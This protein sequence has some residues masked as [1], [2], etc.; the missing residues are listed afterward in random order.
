MSTK[1]KTK[2]NFKKVKKRVIGTLV[3]IGIIS[4]VGCLVYG[5]WAARNILKPISTYASNFVSVHSVNSENQTLIFVLI[6]DK[7][8]YVKEARLVMIN[9]QDLQVK[10]IVIPQDTLVH[11]PYGLNEFKLKS[12]YKITQLEKPESTFNLVNQ[13]L[14]EYFGISTQKMIIVKNDLPEGKTFD[15]WIQ[16]PFTMFKIA[17]DENWVKQNLETNE[18]R[19]NILQIAHQIQIIP[20]Q[21]K[22]ELKVEQQGIVELQKSVDNSS[23]YITD[24]NKLD[25]YIKKTY[26]T[27]AILNEKA[28]IAIQNGTESQG[29]AS[30]VSRIISNSGGVVIELKNADKNQDTTNIQIHDKK[31]LNSQTLQ[32][33]Q[34]TI[35]GAKVEINSEINTKSDITIILGRDYAQIIT[36]NNIPQTSR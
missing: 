6:L 11:L 4:S 3:F 21:N 12:L 2:N 8:N 16:D 25:T 28:D 33:I 24:Q 30:K 14:I 18:S 29:L 36:G 27:D 15:K 9:N 34:S 31:W 20:D 35:P 5:T 26:Q 19:L 32:Q 1:R 23:V 7:Q 22:N 17:F 10:E 13:T